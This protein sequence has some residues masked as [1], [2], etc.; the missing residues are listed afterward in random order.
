MEAA[1]AKT[2]VEERE[3][4]SLGKSDDGVLAHQALEPRY[5]DLA[6]LGEGG[7]GEVRLVRDLVVGRDIAMKRVR[8]ALDRDAYSRER[9]MREAR[10]QGQLEHPSIVPVYDLACTAEG[11]VY[12]TMR[13]VRGRALDEC[14][15]G[16]SKMSRHAL[17]S[18]MSRVCLVVDYAHS[19]GVIHRDIKP[20]NV[21]IG[22]YGEVYLLDWGLAKLTGAN[23]PAE[24]PRAPHAPE[25]ETAASGKTT[26]GSILGTPGY[27][28][29]EQARGEEVDERADVYALGAC[30]FEVLAG[31]PLVDNGPPQG[32]LVATLEGVDARVSR[33][34]SDDV[35]VEL[36]EICVRATQKDRADRFPSAR[37]LSDAIERFLEGDR[38]LE[39]RRAR[40]REH[41]ASAVALVEGSLRSDRARRDAMREVGSALANDPD[42]AD[43]RRVLVRLLTDPPQRLPAE[44][45]DEIV[46]ERETNVEGVRRLAAAAFVGALL[47]NLVIALWM[48]IRNMPWFVVG[49]AAGVIASVVSSLPQMASHRARRV[50]VIAVAVVGIVADARVASPF[51]AIP[52]MALCLGA[53]LA[54]FPR[55]TPTLAAVGA[56]ITGLFLPFLL[57][58]SGLVAPSFHVTNDT[59]VI[60]GQMA[61]LREVPVLV[62][63]FFATAL[64]AVATILYLANVRDRLTAAERR[65]RLQAW[66]LRQILPPG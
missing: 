51:V 40:A 63:Y 64:P 50:F 35:P 44:V 19:H 65:I 38:D 59:I 43:A 46:A 16:P 39:R 14:T 10:V 49:T 41:A 34:A 28:P 32:M 2:L 56:M 60:S 62:W 17:L 52:V 31:V 21:M 33:R 58:W 7:M 25:R 27:M 26:I 29:P 4:V 13:R 36:E 11:R 48:G 54:L 18:A 22:D 9:F 20:A 66:Q 47:P 1:S 15:T 23:E 6:P 37:A 45:S 53:G 3:R 12:F 42:N 55:K 24:L 30:L 5:R 61:H 8:G 57:E